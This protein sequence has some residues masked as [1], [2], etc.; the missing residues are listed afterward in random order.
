MY[1][2]FLKLL[3]IGKVIFSSRGALTFHFPSRAID[4]TPFL[5]MVFLTCCIAYFGLGGLGEMPVPQKGMQYCFIP[6]LLF[7]VLPS[8]AHLAVKV[9]SGGRGRV[10]V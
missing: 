3:V 6:L 9:N 4:L 5:F 2:T 7:P 10:R 8:Q 1:E